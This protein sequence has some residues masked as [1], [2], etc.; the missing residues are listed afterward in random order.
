MTERPKLTKALPIL[1][2]LMA[3]INLAPTIS[4]VMPSKLQSLYGFSP[5][6]TEML[7]LMQHRALAIG[8]VG[9]ALAAAAHMPQLRWPALIGGVISMSS[10]VIF[11]AARGQMSGPLG[12]IALVDIF[13]LIFA[14]AAAFILFQSKG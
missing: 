10:F 4:A 5:E 1:F 9:F 3:L 12:K 13:G 8:L 6:N 14:A 11:T 7:T 2:W